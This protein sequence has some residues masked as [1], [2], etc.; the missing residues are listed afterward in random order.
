MSATLRF[1]EVP[2]GGEAFQIP[3]SGYWDVIERRDDTM[4]IGIEEHPEEDP[5]RR[6]VN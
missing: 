4:V 5:E 1:E 3:E 6:G 2:I